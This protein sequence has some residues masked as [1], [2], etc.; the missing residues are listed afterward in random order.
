[1]N[2]YFYVLWVSKYVKNY[3][4]SLLGL[5]KMFLMLLLKENFTWYD[6]KE[7]NVFVNKG[8]YQTTLVVIFCNNLYSMSDISQQICQK[9]SYQLTH[10]F[11][12]CTLMCS[13]LQPFDDWDYGLKRRSFYFFMW[14]CNLSLF[15]V[16]LVAHIFFL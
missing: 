7:K 16:I 8:K 15:L 9:Q 12:S 5:D 10:V 13:I 3:D 1:M 11:S 2:K 14:L 6:D 4:I